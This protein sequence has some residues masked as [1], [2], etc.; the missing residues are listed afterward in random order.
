MNQLGLK[1]VMDVLI[2]LVAIF[3]PCGQLSQ[4]Y[5]S[6][7]QTNSG[8]TVHYIIVLKHTIHRKQQ[9]LYT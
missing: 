4:L 5:I 9:L 8:Y 1:Q 7:I 2:S 6:L 3:S